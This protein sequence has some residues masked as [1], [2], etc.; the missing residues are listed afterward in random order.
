MMHALSRV[1]AGICLITGPVLQGIATFYWSDRYQ[2]I[3]AGTLIL[4][5]ALCW[6]VGLVAVFRLVEPRVP[7][8]AAIALPAAV[9]GCVGGAS[10][11]LQGL[12]EELFG[13][14]HAQAVR[15]LG[16]HPAAAYIGFWFAGLLFPISIFVLGVALTRIRAVPLPIGVLISV[17]AATFPLSRIPRE[18]TIAHVADLALLVPFTYLGARIA[19]GNFPP[20]RLAVPAPPET[21]HARSSR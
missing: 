14:P 1:I 17:S 20:F 10:F 2:G 16:A 6:I 5:A 11:G 4:V 15:L 7:R 13:V 12:H 19:I 9:Y 18:I 3:A 21:S 8:Y